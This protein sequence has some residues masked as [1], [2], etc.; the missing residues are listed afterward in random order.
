MQQLTL[1]VISVERKVTVALTGGCSGASRH[2][3]THCLRDVFQLGKARNEVSRYPQVVI[4]A[5]RHGVVGAVDWGQVVNPRILG[6]QIYGAI[7]FGPR[8]AVCGKITIQEV[9]PA[10]QLRRLCNRDPR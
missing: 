8:A 5:S 4:M 7:I 10:S 6:Q 1:R 2:A 3:A 9:K